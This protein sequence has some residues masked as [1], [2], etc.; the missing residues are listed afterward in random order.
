[1][2]VSSAGAF[3]FA[4]AL[5]D[6]GVALAAPESVQTLVILADRRLEMR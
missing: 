6:L 1:M 3:F 2:R 5:P 4:C